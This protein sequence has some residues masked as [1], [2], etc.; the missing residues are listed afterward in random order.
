MET[1]EWALPLLS[2]ARYKGACGGRG[3]GKSHF[4]AE[5]MVEECVR[6]TTRCVCAREIQSS[7]KMSSKQTIE[8]KIKKFK[9][10]NEFEILNNRIINTRNGSTID[11]IGIQNHTVSS[12]KSS[13]GIDILWFEEAQTMSMLSF[14]SIRPT[15]RKEGAE[16]W[17][18]WNPRHPDDPIEILRSDPP[19]NTIVVEVNYYDNPWFYETSLKDDMEYDRA[20]DVDTYNH[21]WLGQFEQNSEAKVFKNWKIEEFETSKEALFKFGADWGSTDPTV[22]IRCYVENRKIF[23]DYEAYK[24]NCQINELELLFDSIP[25][26]RNYPIV[27]DNTR[28]DLIKYLNK[29]GFRLYPAIKGNNSLQVGIDWLKNYTII[30]HPRCINTIKELSRYSYELDP[31]SNLPTSKFRD[32][33]NHVIDALRYACE[34]VRRRIS[35]TQRAV[36]SS[37]AAKTQHYWRKK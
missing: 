13:E 19:P 35:H 33:D 36:A 3:S 9:L 29:Q 25:E 23:I 22:L 28:E 11:F 8:D 14:T 26:A 20:R 34:A 18:S 30:V 17:F 7:I 16:M 37:Y 6:K 15:M 12:I 32:K 5:L 21:V 27:A 10:E 1:P 4:F 2:H 31:D 24:L